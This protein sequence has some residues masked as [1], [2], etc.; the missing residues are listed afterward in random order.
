MTIEVVVVVVLL[1]LLLLLLMMISPL[2]SRPHA[3]ERWDSARLLTSG[4]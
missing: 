4:V 3:R 1:L 2:T